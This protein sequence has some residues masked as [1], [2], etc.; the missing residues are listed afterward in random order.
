MTG[1]TEIADAINEYVLHARDREIMRRSMIDGQ[2]YEA[3]AEA[4]ELSPRTVGSRV[5]KWR[6]HVNGHLRH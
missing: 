1:A 5:R 4:M 3:I 6:P 2:T